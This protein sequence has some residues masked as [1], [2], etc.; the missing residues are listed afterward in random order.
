M[1]EIAARRNALKLGWIFLIVSLGLTLMAELVNSISLL[2]NFYLPTLVSNW[3]SVIRSLV[4][5][6]LLLLYVL[7][8]YPA[9]SNRFVFVLSLV[10]L[11]GAP[12]SS[13]LVNFAYLFED[14]SITIYTFLNLFLAMHCTVAFVL[15]IL[16]AIRGCISSTLIRIACIVTLGVSGLYAMIM[17]ILSFT[18][19]YSYSYYGN[20]AL[21]A[22]RCFFALGAEPVFWVS[23]MLLMPK[24]LFKNQPVAAPAAAAYSAQPKAAAPQ[25]AAQPQ[26]ID[27]QAA[28]E[29]LNQLYTS[30]QI[31]QEQYI[32]YYK[33]IFGSN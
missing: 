4:P 6:A 27:N 33:K 13:F 15:L 1:N 14:G 11:A 5:T 9:K 28:L 32:E 29:K 12:L 17:L 19:L 21:Y 30:G 18:D 26:K 16:Q 3:S 20:Y 7:F 8:F 22:I 31:T 23:M 10:L 24:L 25:A 2:E